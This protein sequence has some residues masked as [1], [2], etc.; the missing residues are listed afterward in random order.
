MTDDE[1]RVEGYG[2]NGFFPSTSPDMPHRT[3]WKRSGWHGHFTSSKSP[4]VIA[5]ALID[6]DKTACRLNAI[7][8]R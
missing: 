1:G 7:A 4:S 2:L 6:R 8:V 5:Y 3:G